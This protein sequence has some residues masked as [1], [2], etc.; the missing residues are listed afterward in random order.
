MIA[1]PHRT[2]GAL[3]AASAWLFAGLTTSAQTTTSAL[4]WSD[5]GMAEMAAPTDSRATMRDV[6]PIGSAWLMPTP[7][8]LPSVTASESVLPAATFATNTATAAACNAC[9]TCGCVDC[10]CQP[11]A[12]CCGAWVEFIYL[13]ASGVDMAHAQQQNGT[14]GA[15]TVPFGRTGTADPSYQP[16]I[17]IGAAWALDAWSS[18]AASY[19][20]YESNSFSGIAPPLGVGTP[21]VGSLVHD[22][23]TLL[24]A[25]LGPVTAAYNI[26]FQMVD[27]DFR[28]V[29]VGCPRYWVNYS[30]GVR[31]AH[32]D[33]DFVQRGIFGGGLGG[34]IE[35]RSTINFDGGGF[36]LGLDGE[37]LC[38]FRGFSVYGKAAVAPM[39]GQFYS[40]YD[41]LNQT[42]VTPLAL[43]MWNDDR[44]VT[45]LEYELG[46]RWTSPAA[47]WR[48]SLGYMAQFWFNAITTPELIQAVQ[49]D[50]Y[51]DLGDTISFDGL[52]SRLEFRW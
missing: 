44:F 12:H 24:T 22:P 9:G 43:A 8:P 36:K 51:V 5:H 15:G 10:C 33:Q 25:S 49:T 16:G 50:N 13:Q 35:T 6:G 31:F 21:A 42:T 27:I 39:I 2:L 29:W 45:N 30:L 1:C 23:A 17:R 3:L 20:W 40:Q 46:I 19:T 38:G 11:W 37:R 47:R 52:T 41:L 26:D 14:G 48:V 32:L 28:R 7:R 4:Y 34:A 18:I